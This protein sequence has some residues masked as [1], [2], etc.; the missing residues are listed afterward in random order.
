MADLLEKFGNVKVDV[1]S[2]VAESDNIACLLMQGAYDKACEAIKQLRSMEEIHIA[3]QKSAIENL[4]SG[5]IS[6][7]LG[8]AYSINK[9]NH[10]L[11][12]IHAIFIDDIVRWF[13]NTYHVE[14]AKDAIRNELVPQLDY[15]DN[16]LEHHKQYEEKMESLHIRYE[17]VLDL[18][19]VQLGGFTFAERA[20]NELKLKCFEAAHHSYMHQQATYS[21]K[22]AIISLE[23]GCSCS[24]YS[25]DFRLN[26]GAKNIVRGLIMYEYG[27]TSI[28]PYQYTMLLDYEFSQQLIEINSSKVA[29][30]KCFKNTRV[31]IRFTKEQYAREFVEMFLEANI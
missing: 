1:T 27:Q 2:K 10:R 12:D 11:R 18:I 8:D 19:I 9:I 23:Y 30:I 13:E 5:S 24:E 17:D 4:P 15:Y 20:L 7:Y 16:N 14:L 3:A 6:D 26:S 28:M 22:K 31:D 29:S 21:Q 25:G